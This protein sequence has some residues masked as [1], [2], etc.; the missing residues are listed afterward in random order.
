MMFR[1]AMIPMNSAEANSL[2]KSEWRPKLKVLFVLA[3]VL[4]AAWGCWYAS[5]AARFNEARAPL[6]D[7]IESALSFVPEWRPLTGYTGSQACRTCH[8]EQFETYLATAHSRALVEVDSAEEPADATFDHARSGRRYR[9]SRRD[10][11]LIHTES[12]PLD[13]GTEFVLTSVPVRYR[14][15]SGHF[16]RTYL[17]DA[18]GGLFVESPVSWYESVHAW[19]MT[20][21]YDKP[22]HRSFTRQVLEN[23]LW[24]HAGLVETSTTSHMRMRIVENSIGC[25]RCHG[26]GEAHVARQTAGQIV[27]DQADGSIINPQR[28]SRKLSEAVCQQCHL[29]GDIHIGGRGVRAS[30]YRPGQPLEEFATVYRLRRLDK[31]ITV[32]GHVEQL[33][34]SACYRQSE[35]LTCVTC[36]NPHRP[37]AQAE[38]AEHYRSI[39]MTCHADPGCKVPLAVRDQKTE[40]DCIGCHMPKSATEVPHLAFTHHHIGIHPLQSKLAETQDSAPLIPL[41][42][43][44][45]LTAADRSRSLGLARLQMFLGQGEE[46]QR[47]AAGQALGQQIEE[48]LQSLSPQE[49]DVEIEFARFAFNFARGDRWG[50]ELSASR[51]LVHPDLRSEEEAFVLERLGMHELNQKQFAD[52]RGRFGKLARLRCNGQDWYYLGICEDKCGR[53]EAALQ[54]LEK[55]RELEPAVVGIYEALAGIRHARKEFDAE[56]R[57]REDIARLQRRVTS[58]SGPVSVS[59]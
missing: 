51:T 19:G 42:D 12:L 53:S 46:R 45:G 33:A 35:T 32:V 49:I 13:D 40:N 29:Q 7:E 38:A 4:A 24:C 54:A 28:L 22:A 5:R 37:V 41:S 8:P 48:W 52:A 34:E 30:D 50:A 21:G 58:G 47:S 31:G 1:G 17:C 55:A 10:G 44:S 6:V 18:G 16:A 20:P 26:P 59:P 3:V 2:R 57:L 27:E 36:H 11:K 15:G 43:L 14:V 9:V 39:C 25:E 56:R 23:C